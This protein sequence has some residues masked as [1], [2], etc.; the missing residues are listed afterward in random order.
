MLNSLC[1]SVGLSV[2][3]VSMIQVSWAHPRLRLLEG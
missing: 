2:R 3:D 1:Q